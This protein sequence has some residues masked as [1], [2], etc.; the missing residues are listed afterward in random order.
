MSKVMSPTYLRKDGQRHPEEAIC[1]LRPDEWR[2]PIM[3]RAQGEGY[4]QQVKGSKAGLCSE[5]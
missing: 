3:R 5:C 2:G 1:K 4:K